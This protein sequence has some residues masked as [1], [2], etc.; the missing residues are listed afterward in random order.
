[1]KDMKRLDLYIFRECLP[2]FLLSL[3]VLSFLLLTQKLSDI[4]DL[5]I[6]KGVPAGEVLRLLAYSYPALLS[7]VLPVCL[8]LAVLLAMSRLCAD[9]EVV[10]MRACGVSLLENLR[11]VF[12]LSTLIMLFCALNTLWLGP[13]GRREFKLAAMQTVVGRLNL[14][15]QAQTFTELSS[16]VWLYAEK[17]DGDTNRME[18][19]FLHTEVGKLAGTV[20]TA[21]AGSVEP[22]QEGFALTLTDA[23]FHQPKEDGGYTRTL[24]AESRILIPIKS[25]LGEAEELTV[26]E[27]DTGQLFA[28]A[29]VE[30]Q[31]RAK[32]EFWRRI[33]IPLSC[34]MLGLLGGALGNHHFR[35]GNGRGLS[36]CVA[37]LFINYALFT[38]GDTLARRQTLPTTLAM[39]TPVLGLTALTL[40]VVAVKSRE[41]E[42]GLE[43]T[44][45]ALVSRLKA[46]F[47]HKEE[48]P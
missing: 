4:F 25:G 9:S 11:P 1:M 3:G 34:L 29:F 10:V 15:A 33:T 30:D 12:Y 6:A 21:K 7:L 22:V 36:L 32:M 37:V 35:S 20:V 27:F 14:S 31:W 18:G 39:W 5:V 19:I 38:L 24:A 43:N 40:Y 41:R 42:L 28:K 26:R 23:Q 13:L 2:T 47:A 16:G 8:L 44:V 46:L 48:T 17:I 45:F